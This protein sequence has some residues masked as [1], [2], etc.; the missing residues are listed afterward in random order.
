MKNIYFWLALLPSVL[1]SWY[2]LLFCDIPQ[3]DEFMI[4]AAI[5]G[6]LTGVWIVFFIFF[7]YI[8]IQYERK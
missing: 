6:I 8:Y 2:W 5:I 3:T 1:V 4:I 7:I